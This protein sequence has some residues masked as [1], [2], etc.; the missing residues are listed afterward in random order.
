MQVEKKKKK[1]NERVLGKFQEWGHR[2]YKY[3]DS[4]DQ[5]RR[6]GLCPELLTDCVL[7]LLPVPSLHLCP[8]ST[9]CGKV[10]DSNQATLRVWPE[11]SG[12]VVR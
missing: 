4:L 12:R 9:L 8:L 11:L 7:G 10:P 3:C 6:D 2:V 1:H 5:K